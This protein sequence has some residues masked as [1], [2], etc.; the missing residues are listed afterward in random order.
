MNLLLVT[1]DTDLRDALNRVLQIGSLAI[2]PGAALTGYRF[3][4]L[5]LLDDPI[6]SPQARVWFEEQ[7]MTKLPPQFWSK[8][9]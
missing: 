4:D 1:Y 3:D 7:V 8:P 9:S 6:R 5:F 2:T